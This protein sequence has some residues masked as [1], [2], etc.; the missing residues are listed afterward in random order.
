[1]PRFIRLLH[2]VYFVVFALGMSAAVCRAE[3]PFRTL[4]NG[5]DLQGWEMG[6]D[7]SWV[8]RD[9][10]CTVV[11]TFDGQE[12]NH[13]YLWWPEPQGDFVLRLEYRLAEDTN[14]GIYIRTADREDPVY[15]GIE[16]QVANSF[17]KPELSRT[18]T[19]GAIYDC[20]A[21][22]KNVVRKPGEWNQCQ[23]TCQGP[24]IEV[25]LNGEKII[26][27]NVD[28]WSTA[29]RNPDGSDNKFATPIQ[30]FARRG[31]IGFQDHGRSVSYR[32]IELKSLD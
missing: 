13:D 11:R 8:V 28:D 7:K 9:G 32:N 30:Q 26:E 18:G 29:R 17:G 14:S 3:A 4:F 24:R 20:L 25:V 22:T 5:R 16:V 27:M 6:P 19:A 23:I 2:D 31:Y 15:T 21:P 12:H 1:M 10:Y